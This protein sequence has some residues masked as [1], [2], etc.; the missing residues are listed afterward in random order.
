MNDKPAS[1]RRLPFWLVISLMANMALIGL[2]AGLL[3]RSGPPSP[4]GGETR[5]A[6]VPKDGDRAAIGH[7]LHEAYGASEE[8]R[9]ARTAVRKALGE[10]VATD[11]YDE[12]AVRDAFR[13]LREAD[14]SV[15]TVTQDSMAKLLATL[16]LEDRKR[17]AVFLM[18][19]PGEM[20]PRR[21]MRP[22]D[23]DFRRDGRDGRDGQGRRTGD[24][25]M[26]PPDDPP[27]PPEMQ[28]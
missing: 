1:P 19:G 10:A 7:V 6:W 21:G 26:P 24:R 18:H 27:P 17:M 2:L 16:P 20:G 13:A 5:F 28:P 12:K 15:N 11:P 9:E 14:D 25:G 8:A 23:R 22:G 4:R 3:L